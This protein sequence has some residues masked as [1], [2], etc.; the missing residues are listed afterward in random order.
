[1]IRQLCLAVGIALLAVALPAAAAE[2]ANVRPG[3]STQEVVRK[4]F[5]APTKQL[6]QKVD[7][8]DSAQWLYEG[9]QAPRGTLK[10]V[11]DFGILTQ[12]GYRAEIVRQM[13][14]EPR[15]GIFN[16]QT[17]LAGWGTPDI[18]DIEGDKKVM[19]YR[20]GLFVYFDKEGWFAERMYF[21]PPQ[22]GEGAAPPRR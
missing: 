4:Q 6:S 19:R 15:R 11:V 5:G 10:V 12:Q 2:W 21:T 17:V 14:L 9:D 13:L 18:A 22:P 8:Y 1:M 3:E 16:R 20:S 7:G